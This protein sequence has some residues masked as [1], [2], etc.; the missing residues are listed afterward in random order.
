[1]YASVVCTAELSLC[2]DEFVQDRKT[3]AALGVAAAAA[4]A[5][6]MIPPFLYNKGGI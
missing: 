2:C 1:M 4:D 6:R 5:G 3:S